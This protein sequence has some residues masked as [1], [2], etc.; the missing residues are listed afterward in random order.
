MFSLLTLLLHVFIY[1]YVYKSIYVVIQGSII[2]SSLLIKAIILGLNVYVPKVNLQC[3]RSSA[4]LN[5][6][7][8]GIN[9]HC[10]SE[11]D[12]NILYSLTSKYV[13]W[14]M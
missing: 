9:D 7:E 5:I 12:S 13:F 8:Q 14:C 10:Q 6:S 2:I 11:Y 3:S 4:A 1:M